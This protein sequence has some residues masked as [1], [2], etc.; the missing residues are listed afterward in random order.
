MDEVMA[1]SECRNVQ[2]RG[3]ESRRLLSFVRLRLTRIIAEN[4]TSHE[5]QMSLPGPNI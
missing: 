5:L 4:G 1:K 2:P 3:D